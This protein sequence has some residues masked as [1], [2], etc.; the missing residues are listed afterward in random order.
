[1]GH[2]YLFKVAPAKKLKVGIF[3]ERWSSR[4]AGTQ[5]PWRLSVRRRLARRPLTPLLNGAPA[6]RS[7]ESDGVNVKGP[8]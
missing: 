5:P 1:M 8:R 3:S 7:G 2:L 4:W 6:F